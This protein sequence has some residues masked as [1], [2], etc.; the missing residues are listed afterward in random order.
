M[1]YAANRDALMQLVAGL[2]TATGTIGADHVFGEAGLSLVSLPAA[3]IQFMG[4]GDEMYIP[5][6]KRRV[7]YLFDVNIY[8]RYTQAADAEANIAALVPSI[9][10]T[11]DTHKRVSWPASVVRQ[12]IDPTKGIEAV[13]ATSAQNILYRVL[14]VH[15]RVLDEEVVAYA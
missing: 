14:I 15:L 11:F 4:A 5:G 3:E 10:D 8:L 7:N 9:L 2:A 12:D 1:S 6:G 13:F